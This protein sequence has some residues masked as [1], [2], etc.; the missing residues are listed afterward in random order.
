MSL[1]R[2]L[3][4]FFWL[5]VVGVSTLSAEQTIGNAKVVRFAGHLNVDQLTAVNKTL[6]EVESQSVSSLIIEINSTSGDLKEVLNTVK[7]IYNLQIETGIKVVVYIE[8]NAIGPAAI[9]PFLADALYVSYFVTWGDIP[10]GTYQELPTNLL[11][12]QVT[13]FI[14]LKKQNYAVLR[15]VAEAMCDP[16]M[17]VVDDGG[18]KVASGLKEPSGTILS[19]KGEPLVLNQNQ[20]KAFNLAQGSMALK[21]FRD[22]FEPE[23]KKAE[24]PK[25]TGIPSKTVEAAS[26]PVEAKFEKFIHF[27]KDG[28]NSIGYIAIDGKTTAIS[29]ST[30]IYVKSALEY[31]KKT[32][33]AFI[34]LKLN[35]PGGEV[36]AAE[37]ISDALQAFDTQNNIPIIAF[38][39]NWAISAGAMLAYSCRFITCVKDASMGAAA[40]VI[41]G[42]GGQMQEASEKV[43]SA[44]RTDFGNRAR[45]FDRNPNIAEAMVD[46]DLILVLRYGKIVRLNSEDQ[47][48]T[49][50]ANQDIVIANKGKLLTLDSIQMIDYGVADLM[51]HP[52]KL[53]PITTEDT[54]AGKWS[55]S[56]ELLSTNSFF[57]SIPNATVD[58]YKMDWKTRFFSILATPLVSSLLMLGMLVGF[59]LEFTTPG[60]TLPGVLGV[61]CLTLIIISNLSLEFANWLEVILMLSGVVMVLIEL[62]I[63]PTGIMGLVGALFFFGGLFAMMLPAI[64]TV[65]FEYDTKTLNIAGE[66]FIRRLA[67]ICSAFVVSFLIIAFLG[68]YMTTRFSGF[69]RFVLQG[70]EQDAAEGYISGEDPRTLPQ[71]GSKG[72]VLATLRPSGKVMINEAIYDAVTAGGFIEKGEAIV[73]AK[74]DGSVII[75]DKDFQETPQT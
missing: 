7:R 47:I 40:P 17:I 73:V 31:Y 9:F 19:T 44:L 56:K 10:S 52:A 58:A 68:R 43:N 27:N 64:D 41:M 36:F 63:L 26:L 50:G 55:F 51:L 75:V 29:Q 49:K 30:W 34:I 11:R 16:S 1:S 57:H 3:L 45:F 24:T 15:T 2:F 60:A 62:F 5:L 18:L 54:A 66:E 13:S 37:N 42:E 33:P 21:A 20:L 12:S 14:P 35:T 65:Q 53:D 46:K 28:N 4:S 74:L 69:N 59:Y 71:P 70:R 22:Q 38:I 8:D 48:R 23:F 32:K 39:D 72:T 25:E 61:T 6:E 67:W